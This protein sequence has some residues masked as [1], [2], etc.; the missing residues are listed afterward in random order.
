MG[1][2]YKISVI[3]PVY[4]GEKYLKKCLKSLEQQTFAEFE[5]IIINDGSTDR[6]QQ[7]IDEF[8]QRSTC[9]V[10][11]IEKENQGQAAARNQGVIL[12]QGKYVVFVD[13]DDYVEKDYLEVLYY[14][15]ES[16]GSDIVSCGYHYVD[17]N[18]A[19]L[20]DVK[21]T[22][23]DW[24]LYGRAGLFAV[25][26]KIFRRDFILEKN[27]KFPENGKIFEDAP[28]SISAKFQGKNPIVIAYSGYYYVRRRG[29][30]MNS[31]T[32]KSS[33]FPYKKMTESIDRVNR[34]VKGDTRERFEFEILHF[35]SGFLFRYCRRADKKDI[36]VLVKYSES[37]L[38]QY[39]PNYYKNSYMRVWN[40]KEQPLIEKCAVCMLS[41]M[42]RIG[43]LYYFTFLFTRI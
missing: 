41:L 39:F 7:I 3:I 10:N 36:K 29:S 23:R 40:N 28:F 27:M 30:T 8:S 26:G 18:G 24:E 5:L 4:N 12:A 22:S 38:K 19:R 34:I 32:V 1:N 21:L 31:G 2:I 13:C 6:S 42:S 20:R 14:A 25:W 37:I 17:E 15:A 43:L 35:F 11:N 9:K 33:R 16:H